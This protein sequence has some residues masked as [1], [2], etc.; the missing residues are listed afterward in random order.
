MSKKALGR[1]LSALLENADTDIT[2]IEPKALHSIAEIKI[3]QIIAN[4]FQ[5]RIEFVEEALNELAESIKVH[6]IIQPITVR[7]VGYE[8]YEIISGERRTRASILA[9]R[10]HIPAYIRLADDQQMLE[11]ALIENIQRENLN[12]IE[13]A[14]SYQRLLEEC[15]LKQDELGER[16]GKKRSTVNNYLRLLKL[17]DEIQLAIKEGLIMMGHARALVNVKNTER[18][19]QIFKSAVN[20]SL[21]VRQ[22]EEMAKEE[23]EN[24]G[25]TYTKSSDR[26]FDFTNYLAQRER[27]SKHLNT[28]IKFKSRSNNNGSIIINFSSKEELE[29]ILNKLV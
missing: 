17:P 16:V 22:V 28:S 21:S 18:Q 26:F 1:G 4:P 29:A 23:R 14:L 15:G 10:S 25:G 24:L 11:M 13:V 7:K 6:G 2:S 20:S 27:I 12:A 9:Q 5:P 8:K 3:N 19:L